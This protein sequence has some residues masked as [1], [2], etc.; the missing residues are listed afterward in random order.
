[1][2]GTRTAATAVIT[3]NTAASQIESGV[4]PFRKANAP[5]A[6]LEA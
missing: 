6:A 5:A 2:N 4:Y 1:M 3:A